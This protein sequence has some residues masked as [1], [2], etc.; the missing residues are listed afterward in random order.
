MVAIVG[1][2]ISRRDAAQ[3][4]DIPLDMAQRHG[5]PGFISEEAL[6]ALEQDPPPWLVQS[7]A[8]RASGGRPVWVTLKCDICGHSESVRPKKWWPRFSYL[9]CFHHDIWDLPEPTSG[10]ARQEFDEIGGY[11]VGVFDS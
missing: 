8:N 10:L 2:M 5:I 3:R 1:T 7:R 11:F 6:A 4:L 9:S